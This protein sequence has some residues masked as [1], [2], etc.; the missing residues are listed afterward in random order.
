MGNRYYLTGVQLGM[1]MRTKE[2]LISEVRA[3][4]KQKT[5][6]LV[7]ERDN[8]KEEFDYYIN[9][10]GVKTEEKF[11]E[12]RHKFPVL[13][14]I[15]KNELVSD[16]KSDYNIII[17]GDNYH[18]LVTLNFTHKGKIDVIYID[19]PYN[20]GGDFRYNDDYVKREDEYRHSKWLSFM[21]KRLILAK[22]LLRN[23]GVMFISIDE[24]EFS[25]LSILCKEIFRDSQVDYLVWK[26]TGDGRDGKMKN[27]TTFRTD[28][29][30]II[31]CYKKE[32]VLNKIIE[33]PDFK[34]EYPNPDND[35]RGP[36]KCGSISRTE[37]SSN[38][39]SS[40]YYTIKSPSGR[41][42]T[43]QFD[44]P[45]EKLMELDGDGRIYWGKN[46]DCVP[47]LKI[48]VEEERSITPY[49]VLSS[50]GTTTEGTKE[51]SSIL[52]I[53]C[54]SMRPKPTKLIQTII[55]LGLK[56]PNGLILDFFAGTG[57]TAHAVLKN[58]EKYGTSSRFIVCTDNAEKICSDYCFPRIKKVIEGYT[59]SGD[60]KEELF[61]ERLSSKKIKRLSTI[62]E[63][64]DMVRNKFKEKY[65]T[66]D[67]KIENNSVI[68][69]GIN[70][71][72]K[73][74][75]GIPSNLKYFQTDFV[76]NSSSD[77]NKRKIVK[78]STE[79]ICLKENAFQKV[80]DGDDWKIFKNKNKY[81]GIVFD[82]DVT[83]DFIE[84]VKNI[85]GK[86]NVYIFSLD[87][88]VPEKDFKE[89]KDRIK[90]C[91]IP[92]AILHVYRRIFK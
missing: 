73:K 44:I 2:E 79:M 15:K 14:E 62:G 71:A 40:K 86:F 7:W 26:K 83:E 32:K 65:D 76:K 13:K 50:K 22:N 89:V 37:E 24:S 21:E 43:R 33:K 70:K 34:N 25:Q 75:K 16:E 77:A 4:K 82:E 61:R 57:T 35:P 23:D 6:G 38:P 5:Y 29:E 58:N 12:A 18:A 87:E 56:R 41:K 66:I 27:T 91:P 20:R 84:E 17:E 59:S 92:E 1:L 54:S 28:H 72:G 48:F 90:L 55:Q 74:I 9:W 8:T 51:V 47:G 69:D 88:S 36:Y 31:V 39:N 46:G 80:K 10:D 63:E 3:L 78:K 53:D 81:L 30:Y 19:P 67:L 11:P 42:V 85:N 49:S 64:L 60:S 52:G 68:I 45:K